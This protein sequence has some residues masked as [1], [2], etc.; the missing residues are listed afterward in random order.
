MSNSSL[1]FNSL[2]SLRSTVTLQHYKNS[3]L[4]NSSCFFCAVSFLIFTRSLPPF[5]RALASIVPLHFVTL[6]RLRFTTFQQYS[7]C[8][9]PFF[10]RWRFSHSHQGWHL[11]P[12]LLIFS[13]IS[14]IQLLVYRHHGNC[15][16]IL[17]AVK[18]RYALH[19][20]LPAA[21]F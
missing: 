17:C 1:R 7:V 20:G 5:G 19:Q 21:F 3:S 9:P 6:R 4:K 11:F 16:V 15:A 10:Q 2:V 14:Q 13:F 12:R 18:G 8:S